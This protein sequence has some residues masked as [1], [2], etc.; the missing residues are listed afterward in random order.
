MLSVVDRAR[1]QPI[2]L[3]TVVKEV[4][5]HYHAPSAFF[6]FARIGLPKDA[7]GA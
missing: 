2:N 4:D 3:R 5:T 7:K 6:A 1:V